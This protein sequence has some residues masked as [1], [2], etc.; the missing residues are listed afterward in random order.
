MRNA[1][2]SACNGL[3]ALLAATGLLLAAGNAHGEAPRPVA[4]RLAL[5]EQITPTPNRV[6]TGTLDPQK[7][8]AIASAEVP[9]IVSLQPHSEHP[10]FDEAARAQALGIQRHHR[11]IAGADDL[12]RDAA[13]WLDRVLAAIGDEAAVLHCASGNRV[14]ALIALRAAWIKG[15]PAEAAIAEGKRWGLT[16]LESAVR[17]RLKGGD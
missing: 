14:G 16:G 12:D 6:V 7:L 3:T 13:L 11:P 4:E 17:E 2:S 8:K 15:M 5:P 9:H 1:G 10:D